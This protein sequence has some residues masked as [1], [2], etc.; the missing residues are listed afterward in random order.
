MRP[1][2][3]SALAQP[4]QQQPLDSARRSVSDP[5]AAS[6]ASGPGS[7]RR[8]SRTEDEAGNNNN[9][10]NA[11]LDNVLESVARANQAVS[12]LNGVN[13]TRNNSK[14]GG[15]AYLLGSD[16]KTS[17][18]PTTSSSRYGPNIGAKGDPADRGN[19]IL[20]PLVVNRKGVDID[21]S[22]D[23]DV[24]GA[25]AGGGAATVADAVDDDV[26][27]MQAMLANALIDEDDDD[28]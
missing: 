10:V 16:E 6:A 4:Q 8:R 2:T 26:A 20:S 13:F 14:S 15:E 17:A 9:I 1:S 22:D 18:R 27:Q 28:N 3:S 5:A 21:F 7:S 12:Q 11:R 19:S 23:A 24:K 25:H